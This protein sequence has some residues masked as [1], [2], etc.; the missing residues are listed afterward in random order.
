MVD[1][2]FLNNHGR[3]ALL[4]H[5]AVGL[6]VHGRTQ[7][8]HLLSLTIQRSTVHKY[9]SL[10]TRGNPRFLAHIAPQRMLEVAVSLMFHSSV[11]PSSSF[12]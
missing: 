4:H 11:V 6:H 8:L 7:F 2:F 3:R 12:R 1:V 9:G 5:L 10:S